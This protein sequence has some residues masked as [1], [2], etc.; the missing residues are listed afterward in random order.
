M[1]AIARVSAEATA[2]ASSGSPAASIY[3]IWSI[4][5]PWP[6]GSGAFGGG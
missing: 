3:A 1:D 6:G 2:S 4:R 5:V